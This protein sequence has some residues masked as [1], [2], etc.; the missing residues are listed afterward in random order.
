LTAGLVDVHRSIGLGPGWTWR[1][2]SLERLGIGLLRLD[3]VLLGPGLRPI[4]LG[5]DCPRA[6]D[7]C[8]MTVTFSKPPDGLG[9]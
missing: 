8:R 4:D 6:G 3:L 9:V 2:S 1:P 7:H 5:V